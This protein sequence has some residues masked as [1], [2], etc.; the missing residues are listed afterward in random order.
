[1][2]EVA[3]KRSPR[4]DTNVCV[5]IGNLAKDVDVQQVGEKTRAWINLA[6]ST[7]DSTAWLNLTDWNDKRIQN[8]APFLTK[9]K[10]VSVTCHV[11][12]WTQE[13]EG[14]TTYHTGFTVDNIQ[15]LG[16]GN[17]DGA[18]VANGAS[19]VAVA[20]AAGAD[21]IPF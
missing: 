18:A 14:V 11:N 10:Q 12:T 7:Y 8:I 20:V 4:I 13:K 2:A 1:M 9:G 3:E 5:F 16:G 19:P 21:D 6:V 15:L 17:A